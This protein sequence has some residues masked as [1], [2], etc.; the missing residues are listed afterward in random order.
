MSTQALIDRLSN[1]VQF[2]VLEEC[3]V[4]LSDTPPV[5]ICDDDDIHWVQCEECQHWAHTG[6]CVFVNDVNDIFLCDCC[7]NLN[8][9]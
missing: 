1:K 7:I 6:I 2:N 4:C 3:C 8:E 5:D 9:Q